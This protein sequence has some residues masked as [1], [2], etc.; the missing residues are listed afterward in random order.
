M[1]DMFISKYTDFANDLLKTCPELK[2][3]ID[4]ALYISDV[5]KVAQFK[6]RVLPTCSPKRDQAKCPGCVLPGVVIT[7]EMWASFSDKTKAAVQ[8]HLTLLS[9]C[10]LIDIGTKDD[11]FGSD[12]TESWAKTMMDDMK[13]KMGG[14][15]FADIT[16]KMKN[17]FGSMPGLSGMPGMPG[18]PGMAGGFPQL[19]E[20][21]LKG[22]IARLA[23][24]IVKELNIEDFGISAAD[25]EATKKDPSKTLEIML[26]LLTKNPAI[27]QG[28]V[29]KLSKKLQQKIQSGS[30]RP[31]ELMAEA[32]ELM[33]VFSDNPQFVQM[34]ESFRNAFG[35]REDDFERAAGRQPNPRLSLVKERLKKKLAERE[36]NKNK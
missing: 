30:I 27:L 2:G 28:T 24:E 17:L 33:K 25:V 13:S 16:E 22:Q 23:E 6:E 14:I 8:E 31:K 34:M 20:K 3:D 36:K 19:P 15:D 12:W 4:M 11:V 21:F 5:D 10:V 26:N 32:E 35:A 29:Q 18:M 7:E 1:P 9:F